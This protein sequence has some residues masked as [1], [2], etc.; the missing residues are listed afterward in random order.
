MFD[1]KD[2]TMMPRKPHAAGKSG[3]DTM[4]G[5]RDRNKDGRFRVGDLI[6]ER[7]KVLSELGQGGMGVVYKWR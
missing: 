5:W 3:K 6:M 7:Y 1:D 4:P 2:K